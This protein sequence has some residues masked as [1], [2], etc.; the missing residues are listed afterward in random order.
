MAFGPEG[1]QTA[2]KGV[3]ISIWVDDVDAVY[4]HCLARKV[5]R[6][7][8][9]QPTYHGMCVKR[10][11]ATPMGTFFDSAKAWSDSPPLKPSCDGN[12]NARLQSFGYNHAI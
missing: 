11:S 5:W 9:R 6:S 1:D 3:W 7:P 4:R 8:G 12:V 10:T 2:D